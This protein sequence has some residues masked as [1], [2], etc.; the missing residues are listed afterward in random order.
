MIDIYYY[1]GKLNHS[2]DLS[3]VK[4]LNDS[5]PVWIDIINMTED[6]ANIIQNLFALHPLT[7]EDL[8]HNMTRVKI[9]EFKNY[10]FCVFYCI[11]SNKKFN[12]SELDFIIGNKFIITNHR[13]KLSSFDNLKKDSE[14]LISLFKKDVSFIFHKLIDVEVD[15]YFPFIDL[16]DEEIESLSEMA[17]I[18]PS[19]DLLSK[20]L[21]M[22]KSIGQFKKVTMYQREKLSELSKE[23]YIV[24]SKKLKPYLRDVYDHSI[25][26]SDKV[27]N[28]REL[29]SN[30]F[31]V[32]MSSVSNN[33]NEVMKTLSIIATIALPLSVISGIYGT[34]FDILPGQHM[35][36]GFW[37]MILVMAG[38][39][40][41]MIY[42]FKKRNWF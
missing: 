41:V 1:D 36:Y 18:K 39:A 26:I 27:D 21:S 31:D 35:K 40:G 11:E 14:L 23:N 17:A 16:V 2:S 4:S 28:L 33:M 38:M 42:F 13:V 5:I 20:I 34:N 7:I 24:F 29:V 19:P 30:A 6:D 22:K 9:E 15:E 3:V 8:K 25:R 12:T 32:Y 37:I 10:L